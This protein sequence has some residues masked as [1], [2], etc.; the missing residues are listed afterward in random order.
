VGGRKWRGGGARALRVGDQIRES[1][2]SVARSGAHLS[3]IFISMVRSSTQLDGRL[4]CIA[5]DK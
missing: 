2:S 3:Y 5:G 4:L 1:N